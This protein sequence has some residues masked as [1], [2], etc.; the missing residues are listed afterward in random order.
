MTN[1][2]KM[3]FEITPFVLYLTRV[4]PENLKPGDAAAAPHPGD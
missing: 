1:R 4:G 3:P 2:D